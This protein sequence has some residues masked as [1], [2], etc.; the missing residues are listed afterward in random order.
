MERVPISVSQKLSKRREEESLREL[1]CT[2]FLY[3]FFSNDY[4]GFSQSELLKT[5]TDG[6]LE[7]FPLQ[8]GATG[9]RLISGNFPLIEQTECQIAKFHGWQSALLF[10]SGYTA[11]VGVFSTLVQREDLVLYD[12]L[13]HASI[14]D[15]IQ[16]T[17]GKS[18]K[19]RHNDL[20]D[21]EQKLKSYHLKYKS[22]YVVTESVFSM[23]GDI[24]NLRQMAQLCHKYNAFFIVDEAHAVGVFGKKGEGLISH[25]GLQDQTLLTL[26]TYG[27]ALGGHG[28]CVLSGATIREY[29]VNFCRSF[30]YTTGLS[31]H[32]VAQIS[33]AYEILQHTHQ[34]DL[35]HQKIAYFKKRSEDYQLSHQFIASSSPIQSIVVGGNHNTNHLA[36]Y[37]QKKGF[38][39]KAI[40]SPTVGKGSERIRLCLHTFNSEEQ[41]NQL[42]REIKH[43][44]Q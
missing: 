35:L 24:P 42:L 40:L 43:Y 27:K 17:S 32:A 37:L 7:R 28:A 31:P 12:V 39:A 25:L 26:V 2:T 13:I 20:N 1:S 11:N 41:I 30:I 8:N 34:I 22:V 9:S 5:K 36:K 21:L 16:M 33:A 23:D 19:F 15:G 4:L 3:D 10:T 29:L 18:L 6:I 38:A 14:R 44:N